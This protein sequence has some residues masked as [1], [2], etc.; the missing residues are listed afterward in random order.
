M[1]RLFWCERGEFVASK[2]GCIDQDIRVLETGLQL[3]ACPTSYIGST[4]SFRLSTRRAARLLPILYCFSQQVG[5]FAA[6]LTVHQHE[7]ELR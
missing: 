4:R 7:A 1:E 5:R 3:G 6:R 2:L